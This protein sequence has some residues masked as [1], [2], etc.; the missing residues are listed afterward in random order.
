[1]MLIIVAMKPSL[2]QNLGYLLFL[3]LHGSFSNGPEAFL[4]KVSR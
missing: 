1:M 2:R 3:K 4:L